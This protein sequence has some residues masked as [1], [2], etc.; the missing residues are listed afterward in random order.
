MS[1]RMLNNEELWAH[2]VPTTVI[3]KKQKKKFSTSQQPNRLKKN[4]QFVAL[5]NK[6]NTGTKP[7]T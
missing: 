1:L 3:L 5:E 6:T 7:I 4:V 2:T